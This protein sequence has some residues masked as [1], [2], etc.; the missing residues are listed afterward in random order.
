[1][2][3]SQGAD[4]FN[5]DTAAR[6]GAGKAADAALAA[7]R[8]LVAASVPPLAV[9]DENGDCV[10]ANRAFVLDATRFGADRPSPGPSEQAVPFSPDGVRTWRLVS[11]EADPGSGTAADFIDVITDALPMMFSAKDTHS[12]YVLM[13]RYQA[14]IFGVT[15]EQAIGRTAGQIL[16][17]TFGAYTR[18]TDAEVIRTGRP[19]PFFDEE[20][21]GADGVLRHRLTS[22]VPLARRDGTVWGVA[23]VAVDI[24]DRKRLERGLRAARDAAEA[25][26]RAKSGFLAAMSHE[27]RTPLHAIIGFADMIQA[28]A[29]GPLGHPDYRDYA[30]HILRSGRHLLSMIEDVLDFARIGSSGLH[31]ELAPVDLAELTRGALGPLELAAGEAD[32]VL[33]ADLP[34]MG[35]VLSGDAQRLRQ[36]V[37][38]LAGNAIR[39]TPQGGS[40]HLSLRQHEDGG[41]VLAISDSGIGIATADLE[42]AFEPFWQADSS[43]GRRREG[44]GIGLPLARELVRLHGG[45]LV[46][47]SAPGE[48]TVATVTLPARPPRSEAGAPDRAA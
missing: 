42:Y 30:A 41:A 3:G 7:V 16:G 14:K 32:V 43:L 23:V 17:P 29:H 20:C 47:E 25:G 10:A 4:T 28:E 12:R 2:T 33:T 15:P 11:A 40:V 27:L 13:N 22:K 9:F 21:A 5:R 37:L 44:T 24:T 8:A 19:L 35:P 36:I 34:A 6:V 1:M 26:S 48:G 18:A 38:N 45:T 39:F 46:L 31:L